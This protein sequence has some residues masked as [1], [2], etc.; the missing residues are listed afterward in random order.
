VV[1]GQAGSDEVV[2]AKGLA[3]GEVVVT[4]GHVRLR[5]DAPVQVL[6]DRTAKAPA[7]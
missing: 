3:A 2:I 1:V 4:E 5:P 6:D 7:P